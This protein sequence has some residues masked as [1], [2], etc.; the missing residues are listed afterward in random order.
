M[1]NGPIMNITDWSIGNMRDNFNQLFY[2][3]M[4]LLIASE[5]A[6][7]LPSVNHFQNH[8]SDETVAQSS[9]KCSWIGMQFKMQTRQY[10]IYASNTWLAQFNRLRGNKKWIRVYWE[11]NSSAPNV[12]S[13]MSVYRMSLLIQEYAQMHSL[14]FR[15]SDAIDSIK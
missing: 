9:T 14:T 13:P 4:C 7:N 3:Y 5:F 6:F 11:R 10:V 12:H 8:L 2:I 15:N 1:E